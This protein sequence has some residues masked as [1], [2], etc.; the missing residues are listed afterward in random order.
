MVLSDE[1][2]SWQAFPAD[3][4]VSITYEDEV[5]GFCKPDFALRIVETL[6]DD[7]KLR[8][9]LRLACQDIMSRAGGTT[10]DVDDLVERYLIKTT[11]PAAGVAAI[12]ALLRDRQEEL[13]VSDKEFIR[14]CDSYRLPK[15]K[16][17]AIYAGEE[18]ESTMLVP[19]S[20]IVG[21]SVEDI[22]QILEGI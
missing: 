18:I 22:M 1:P 11:A 12:A 5:V 3:T 17:E 4:Y 16:L 6:N 14:F 7:E 15:E 9:A 13:D 21:R 8:K 20:R 2:Q 10:G 19:I